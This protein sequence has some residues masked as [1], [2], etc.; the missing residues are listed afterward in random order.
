MA[1][2]CTACEADLDTGAQH[3]FNEKCWAEA[4]AR[5]EREAARAAECRMLQERAAAEGGR[6]SAGAG[7]PGTGNAPPPG[8]RGLLRRFLDWL[9]EGRPA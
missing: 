6:A 9:G 3:V 4:Q 2:R 5:A 7:R 8:S 1:R